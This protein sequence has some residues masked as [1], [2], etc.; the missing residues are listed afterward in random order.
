MK[1]HVSSSIC[2]RIVIS[3]RRTL[4]S[5]EMLYPGLLVGIDRG[6]RALKATLEVE[7]ETAAR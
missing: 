4:A 5:V 2:R 3:R 6:E 7:L 1:H